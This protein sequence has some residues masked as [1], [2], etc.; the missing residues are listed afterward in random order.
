MNTSPGIDARRG[1]GSFGTPVPGATRIR[2]PG[3]RVARGPTA[4]VEIGA[5]VKIVAKSM[6]K[7]IDRVTND[8]RAQADHF[9]TKSPSALTIAIVGVNFADRY[10]SYEGDRKYPTNGGRYP[11]PAQEAARAEMRINDVGGSYFELLQVGFRATNEPPYRFELVDPAGVHQRYGS[12]LVR[13]A[14]E[15]EQRH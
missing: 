15:Y 11:H 5:E 13:V 2:V 9:R 7:Q 6:I 8:L 12:L 14:R 10:V 4:D 3:F 1:D